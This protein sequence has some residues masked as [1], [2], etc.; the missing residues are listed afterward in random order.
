[1]AYK[2][3]ENRNQ[4][5]SPGSV[6][7]GLGQELGTTCHCWTCSLFRIQLKDE[8][9]RAL[10]DSCPLPWV[11]WAGSWTRCSWLG[12]AAWCALLPVPLSACLQSQ[13]TPWLLAAQ[14]GGCWVS[15]HS[16]ALQPA[17]IMC[18]GMYQLFIT[19][20]PSCM[21]LS[22]VDVSQIPNPALPS[23]LLLVQNP[24]VPSTY[25]RAD[26]QSP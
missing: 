3:A 8:E 15:P 22:W 5:C 11:R 24:A 25:S 1:M 9:C 23:S 19:S 14:Q 4:N 26:L 16:P 6:F 13:G 20:S 21:L 2:T 17:G 10:V 18:C 7:R 12:R